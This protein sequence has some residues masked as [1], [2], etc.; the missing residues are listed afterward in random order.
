MLI[1]HEREKLLQAIN[2]FVRNTKKCGKVKLFKL[3]YFLDFEHFK[4][5]GRS[6]TGLNYNAWPMGPVPV[7]LHNELEA[8]EPDMADAFQIEMIPIRQGTEAMLNIKPQISFSALH[9]SKRES[10]LMTAL[11]AEYRDSTADD[12]IEATHLENKPWDRI[13]NQEGKK[14]QLI[15]YELAIRPDEVDEIKRVAN[16]REEL[17][18]HLR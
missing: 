13:Y 8:P 11:A 5:T 7:S 18:G 16:D 1:S 12:I 4:V 9:F 14:Q 10:D 3:L 17:L 15:P 2:F 6:V